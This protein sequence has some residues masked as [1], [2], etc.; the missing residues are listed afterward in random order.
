MALLRFG[1]MPDSGT[2]VVE[3][4][5]NLRGRRSLGAYWESLRFLCRGNSAVLLAMVSL[6]AFGSG[7]AVLYAVFV[8]RDLGVPGQA[9]GYLAAVGTAMGLLTLL[10]LARR[11]RPGTEPIV[12][13]ASSTL[14]LGAITLLLQ[15]RDITLVLASVVLGGFGGL[16]TTVAN[17]A[18][19]GNITPALLRSRVVAATLAITSIVSLPSGILAGLLFTHLGHQ[20]PWWAA[21]GIQ[22]AIVGLALRLVMRRSHASTPDL[23][24]RH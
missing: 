5:R 4:H 21:L 17:T 2:R 18:L 7:L 15:A 16:I 23:R 14:G 12:L 20:S 3:A 10:P 6:G 19:W 11:I 8:T 9:L 24:A 13:L 1:L 22:A